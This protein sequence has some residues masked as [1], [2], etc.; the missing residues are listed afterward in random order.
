MERSDG[1]DTKNGAERR[2]KW[3][4]I[5]CRPYR[6]VSNF[7]P[8]LSAASSHHRPII[9]TSSSSLK[10]SLLNN[11]Q[12]TYPAPHSCQSQATRESFSTTVEE[13]EEK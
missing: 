4:D 9:V 3:L 8:Y 13:E 5:F 10:K 7:H 2:G 6:N 1:R 12:P 11:A